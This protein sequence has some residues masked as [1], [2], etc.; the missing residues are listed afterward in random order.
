MN[1]REESTGKNKTKYLKKRLDLS[2]IL[3]SILFFGEIFFEN[4]FFR[5]GTDRKEGIKRW[6]NKEERVFL[7]ESEDAS[8]RLVRNCQCRNSYELR[9]VLRYVLSEFIMCTNRLE[10][11]RAE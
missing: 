6:K 11:R 10:L 5:I 1:G 4:K 8:G 2:I 7:N 9:Q 3:R